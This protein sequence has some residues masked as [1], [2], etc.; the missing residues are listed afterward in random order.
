[1]ATFVLERKQQAIETFLSNK[2]LDLCS[3]IGAGHLGL[4]KAGFNCI[5][6]SE[7]DHKA[8]H[9]Y[10]TFFGEKHSNFGDLMTIDTINL[11]N[12]DLLIGGFP[13]QTFSIVGKRNGLK[14]PRGKIIFGIQKILQEK[15]IKYFILE[16]V[17]GLV[18][19]E[20]GNTLHNIIQLL[21]NTGY[22]VY[23]KV[24]NSYGFGVPQLRERLYFVGIR[25]DLKYKNF[26]FP[27][28]Q[29][30]NYDLKE[31][32]ISDDQNMIMEEY[33][34]DWN[35]FNNKYL[36]N[37]YNFGKYNLKNILNENYLILDT[38]QSDLRIYKNK[39]PTLRTGRHGI[40]YVKN[41]KLRKLTG[42]E[43]L[44]LQG[45]PNFL[46][47]KVK[48]NISNTSLLSQA[49]NAM[50]VNVINKIANNLKKAIIENDK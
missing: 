40:L 25:A 19:L 39:I 12:I 24:L 26:S 13:C 32:L 23:H 2:Y 3:G 45:F 4:I 48:N 41:G 8:I 18:N 30:Y 17:K 33:S 36:L 22:K 10:K 47:N 31:F 28:E 29:S 15:N 44:L 7:I 9:T 20:N 43:A 6:F 42:E 35:T 1:M 11:P 46:I 5:G 14:D 34:S 50:T 27:L 38:R 21:Q 37:K 49:G 16:N